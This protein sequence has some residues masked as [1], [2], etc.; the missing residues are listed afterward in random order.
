M[1]SLSGL[2]D[3]VMCSV[4]FFFLFSTGFFFIIFLFFGF[5]RLVL[6]TP[7]S[8]QLSQDIFSLVSRL[9]CSLINK[10]KKTTNKQI[11]RFSRLC[12]NLTTFFQIQSTDHCL[13]SYF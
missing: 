4:V 11:L 10:K 9:I 2:H 7:T 1:G 6:S 13:S 12:N 5:L 3:L 8:C